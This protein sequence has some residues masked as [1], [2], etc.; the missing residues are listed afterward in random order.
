MNDDTEETDDDI[1]ESELYH[2]LMLN[3]A[4]Q[5]R[6]ALRRSYYAQVGSSFDPNTEDVT[7]WE[8]EVNGKPLSVDYYL[9][10]QLTIFS[11]QFCRCDITHY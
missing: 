9:Y 6:Q 3:Q 1:M 2:R 10:I 11:F 7:A 4:Y 8:Q 5:Q